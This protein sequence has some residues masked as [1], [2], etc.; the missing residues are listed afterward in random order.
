MLLNF[1][2]L[3]LVVCDF[4][5]FVLSIFIVFVFEENCGV[6]FFGNVGCKF[7]WFFVIMIFILVVLIF[8]VIV[9]DCY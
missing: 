2:I 5:M 6:W 1:L 3:N 8:V 7:F 9:L 4:I